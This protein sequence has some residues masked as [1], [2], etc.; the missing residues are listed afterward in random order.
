VPDLSDT[1]LATELKRQWVHLLQQSLARIEH[2]LQQLTA[3]QIWYRSAADQNSVGNLLLHLAGN[4]QQWVVHGVAQQPDQ[5]DR[6]SEFTADGNLPPAD[7]LRQL[8]EVVAAAIHVIRRIPADELLQP[9]SIQG[10]QTTVV[11]A[12]MHSIPH[13]VGHTHQIV[14]LTR[15]QL[16]SDYQF[17]WN[18]DEPRGDIPL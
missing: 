7:L 5:R 17:H 3:A 4:L 8:N 15:I 2:C 10:F 14:M 11:G 6:D 12:L 9:R 18:P 16:G 13:F 1:N